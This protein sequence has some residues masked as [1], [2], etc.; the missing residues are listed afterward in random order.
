MKISKKIILSLL[1]L[2]S[3]SI[4]VSQGLTK[5]KQVEGIY[6][7]RFEEGYS[8]CCKTAPGIE[9]VV[10]FDEIL[11]V[12]LEKYALHMDEHIGINFTISFVKNVMVRGNGSEEIS[13]VIR[14]QKPM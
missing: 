7:G 5:I 11:S 10:V 8:F 4:S 13:T 1:F 12:I 9:E 3:F 2:T 14:L 6:L